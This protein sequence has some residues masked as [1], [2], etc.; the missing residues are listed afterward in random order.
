MYTEENQLA[1]HIQILMNK[2]HPQL[3]S[4]VSQ[5]NTLKLAKR[6]SMDKRKMVRNIEYYYIKASILMWLLP[7]ID[8]D[9]KLNLSNF[10]Q[11]I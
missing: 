3:I 4:I 5:K 11:Y 8:L 6:Y 2:C 10:F 9:K 1:M 7:V